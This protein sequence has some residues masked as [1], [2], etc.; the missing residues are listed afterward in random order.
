MLLHVDIYVTRSGKTN[1][2]HFGKCLLRQ[3]GVVM[4]ICSIFLIQCFNYTF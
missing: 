4:I 2:S 1:L 3:W